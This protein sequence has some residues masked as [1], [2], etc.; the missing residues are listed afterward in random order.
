MEI[1]LTRNVFGENKQV[2][3]ESMRRVLNAPPNKEPPIEISPEAD[4]AMRGLTE[5]FSDPK[6]HR[7][8]PLLHRRAD[9]I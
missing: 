8:F 5:L 3:E 1:Y 9:G 4:A 7:Q 2:T 6:E